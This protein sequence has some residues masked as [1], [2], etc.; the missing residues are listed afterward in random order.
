MTDIAKITIEDFEPCLK[1]AFQV[2]GE[3][4]D[5]FELE[6]IEVKQLGN[7]K[8]DK[9]FHQPFSLLF[10][11]PVAPILAQGLVELRNESL[12]EIALFLVPAGPDDR[13]MLYDA[14]FN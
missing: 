9:G 8:V 6:L 7:G 10:R 4:D 11:G 1:Q 2:K 3:P 12:G 13:G 14:T 5:A